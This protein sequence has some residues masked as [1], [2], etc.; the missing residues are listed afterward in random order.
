MR[1]QGFLPEQRFT[2]HPPFDKDEAA[3]MGCYFASVKLPKM[4]MRQG[5][6]KAHLRG[7]FAR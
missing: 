4:A 7:L 3:A 2:V 6:Q 1:L 5:K